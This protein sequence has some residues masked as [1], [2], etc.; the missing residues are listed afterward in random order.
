MAVRFETEWVNAAALSGPELS[1]TWASLHIRVNDAIV[2]RVVDRTDTV[3]SRVYVPLYPLAESLVTNW[4]FLLREIENPVKADDPGF[5]RRHALVSARDGYAFPNLQ[6]MPSGERT[7]LT[8]TPD[9]LQWPRIEFLDGGHAWVDRDEFRECCSDLVARVVQRLVSLDIEGTILQEEW[10]S[11]QA[12]DQEEAIFCETA[13]GL[14]WDP[15]ALDDAQRA[16]V[17]GLEEALNRDWFDEALAVLDTEHPDAQVAAIAAAI[18]TGKS[19]SL[20]LERLRAIDPP[21]GTRPESLVDTPWNAGYAL[22]RCARQELALDDMPLSTTRE[23]AQALGEDLQALKAATK[24]RKINVPELV[25]GVV[26]SDENK[27]PA[28]AIR[29]AYDNTRRFQFCRGLAEVL[30][31]PNSDALLTQARSD[32]QQWSRAFAAEFLAPSAALRARVSR[33]TL[34]ED[35][36]GALAVEFGVSPMLI[37]HQVENHGIAQI[38]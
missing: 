33:L 36:I 23:L 28:F 32:R 11:I 27:L 31:S 4:W 19:A 17:L 35:E 9:R 29:D 26:T 3:R 25:N 1:A 6:V 22:A 5:R 38:G 37:M 7:H 10:A 12:A 20:A 14:G 24:S 13:A 34:D 15:Y 2:T 16:L 8:W 30:A 21:A 18:E